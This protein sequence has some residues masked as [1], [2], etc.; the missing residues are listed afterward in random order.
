MSA[1]PECTGLAIPEDPSSEYWNRKGVWKDTLLVQGKVTV[2][3]RTQY[4][5]YIGDF[6]LHCHVLDHEDTGM[7]QNIRVVLPDGQGP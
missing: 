7:M 6:V 4:R 2:T 3:V 1:S 5:R